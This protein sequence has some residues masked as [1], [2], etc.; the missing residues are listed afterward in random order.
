MRDAAKWLLLGV[1]LVLISGAV[2]H[3]G[4]E[5]LPTGPPQ[6]VKGV[7]RLGTEM[8]QQAAVREAQDNCGVS[9]FTLDKIRAEIDSETGYGKIFGRVTNRCQV[10]KG[11]QLEITTSNRAGDIVSS[12]DI[13]PASTDNIPANSSRTFSW[14]VLN[15]FANVHVSVVSTRTW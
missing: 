2:T 11:V 14:V 12:D 6:F 3:H 13:W 5:V 10:A 1:L 15:S 8:Q 7:A 9:D 4:G